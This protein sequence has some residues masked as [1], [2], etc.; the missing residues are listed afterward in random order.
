VTKIPLPVLDEIMADEV[1]GTGEVMRITGEQLNPISITIR[2]AVRELG[3]DVAVYQIYGGLPEVFSMPGFDPA[4]AGFSTRCVE[5]AS[6]LL[7]LVEN[8]SLLEEEVLAE[9]SE[10]VCLEIMAELALKN[11]DCAAAVCLISRAALASPVISLAPTTI[12]ALEM[13]E[14]GE[15]YMAVWFYGLLHELGHVHAER[16]PGATGM[17][18]EGLRRLVDIAIPDRHASAVREE[19]G[20]DD[21]LN[22]ERLSKE[23]MADRFAADVMWRATQSVLDLEGRRNSFSPVAIVLIILDMFDVLAILTTCKVTANHASKL[24]ADIRDETA[25]NLAYQVRLNG[26]VRHMAELLAAHEVPAAGSLHDADGWLSMLAR[27]YTERRERYPQVE[28]GLRRAIYIALLPWKR[29]PDAGSDLA[30]RLRDGLALTERVLLSRFLDL[31]RALSL[32]HPD[33]RRL[34][35]VMSK[36]DAET[37]T[38]SYRIALIPLPDDYYLPLGIESRY[39]HLIF[40]F[41]SD[42][43][44]FTRYRQ[45]ASSRLTPGT[46]LQDADITCNWEYELTEIVTNFLPDDLRPKARIVVEGTPLFD[47]LM[48]ELTDGAI[49][50][51][52]E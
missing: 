14:Y 7:R 51:Q 13:E 11:G 40:A 42:N 31:A 47:R 52:T 10:Q 30:G 46:E 4:A 43:E 32:D 6:T 28:A 50:A 48:G 22:E 37:E 5:V 25:L 44:H 29:E 38:S 16:N 34:S 19:H 39:G 41:T 27:A 8:G 20:A 26:V 21:P 1:G 23:V 2:E 33:L 17:S 9:V 36:P 18:S 12:A 24:G 15:T 45:I 3:C 49:W 35:A